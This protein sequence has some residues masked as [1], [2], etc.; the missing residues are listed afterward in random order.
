MRIMTLLLLALAVSGCGPKVVRTEQ[1]G[2]AY[3][4]S[5]TD[6]CH[7]LDSCYTCKGEFPTIDSL[8]DYGNCGMKISNM[9]PGKQEVVTRHI[10]VR[11]YFS[12]G[13]SQVGTRKKEVKRSICR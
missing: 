10:P 13:K 7:K 3:L 9:C 1:V 11:L 2:H 12:N 6:S 4:V 5:T 8:D